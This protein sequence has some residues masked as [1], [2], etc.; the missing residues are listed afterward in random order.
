MEEQGSNHGGG[1]GGGGRILVNVGEWRSKA[2][3]NAAHMVP[4][5][6]KHH[7]ILHYPPASTSAVYCHVHILLAGCQ[8]QGFPLVRNKKKF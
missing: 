1:E 6:D 7:D 3:I 4:R 8:Y 2:L 5:Y